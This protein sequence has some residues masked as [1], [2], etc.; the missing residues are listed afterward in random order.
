MNNNNNKVK[1]GVLLSGCGVYDGAEIHESVLT[2]LVLDRLGAEAICIA[3]DVPQHHVVNHLTGQEMPE[4][5]NVL[6]EAARIARG[7][8]RPLG[9]VRVEE[10][11]G[12]AMPGGFG[13]AKNFTKWAFEGPQGA[14]LPEVKNF[15]EAMV[16]AGKPIAAMCMAPTVLAKALEGSEISPR[17]SVGTTAAPSPY[18]IAGISKGMESLGTRAEM[19]DPTDILEDDANNIVTTPCY[20]MENS[21]SQVYEGVEK[22]MNMLVEMIALIKASEGE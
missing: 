11:D 1:I 20:M 15:I 19:C 8:I 16:A 7:N 12:L 10:L 4:T 13:V 17:L 14:I 9:S 5:R 3:P 2:L 18:D 6:V 22:A 21:I